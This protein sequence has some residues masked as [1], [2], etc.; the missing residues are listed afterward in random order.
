VARAPRT[1]TVTA[2]DEERG[3]GEVAADDGT[4]HP[5][6]CVDIADGTRTIEP[7]TPVRYVVVGKLGRY[8]AAAITRR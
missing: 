6:H 3:L 4:V 2:F 5:F 7:G 1:G 8:E